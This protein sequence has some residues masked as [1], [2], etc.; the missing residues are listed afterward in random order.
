MLIGFFIKKKILIG[1]G[2][3]RKINWHSHVS[4]WESYNVFSCLSLFEFWLSS[5]F[6]S[7]KI[8][9][10]K[11]TVLYII[12]I[13]YVTEN[14]SWESSSLWRSIFY[15]LFYKVSNCSKSV[16]YLWTHKQ[17]IILCTVTDF[18]VQDV[19]YISYFIRRMIKHSIWS[20]NTSDIRIGLIKREITF[21][22]Y[23]CIS[24]GRF[25]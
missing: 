16:F 17:L 10:T 3:N 19:L 25:E 14:N 5:C 6:L 18:R 2:E 12:N 8:K 22:P 1:F 11:K 15:R 24:L 4:E 9:I 21:I 13:V 7:K 20:H 23:I